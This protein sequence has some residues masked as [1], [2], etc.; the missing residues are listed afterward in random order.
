MYVLAAASAPSCA[1]QARNAIISSCVA[2]RRSKVVR[3]LPKRTT[4]IL[5]GEL[6]C[7]K[8]LPE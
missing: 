7:L 6:Q 2:A 3:D 1:A 8:K 4:F 5:K